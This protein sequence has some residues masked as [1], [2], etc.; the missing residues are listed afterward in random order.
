[1]RGSPCLTRPTPGYGISRHA[2]GR[3]VSAGDIAE[4]MRTGAALQQALHEMEAIMR[5]AP[6]G[7]ILFTRERRIVRTNARCAEVFGYAAD[8]LIGA[9]ARVLYRS[10]AD[11]KALGREAGPLLARA[12]SFQTELFLRR[13][14]GV[15]IWAN[16]SSSGSAPSSGCA[17]WR[18][19]TR[20]PA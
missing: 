20:S 14:D 12:K 13:K 3:W 15:D 11:Y 17:T 10:D 16:R 9:P 19:T 7:I 4:R 1:A 5:N 18:C 2:G 6:V 8:E